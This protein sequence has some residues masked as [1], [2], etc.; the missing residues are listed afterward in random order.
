LLF[1]KDINE[2]FK[3]LTD[4]LLGRRIRRFDLSKRFLYLSFI[5]FA[6]VSINGH[7]S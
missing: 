5:T 3:A 4:L 7:Q 2:S 1:E 6:K